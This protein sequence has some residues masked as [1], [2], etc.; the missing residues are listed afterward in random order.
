MAGFEQEAF[1]NLRDLL[2]DTAKEAVPAAEDAAAQVFLQAIRS[3]A[4]S[5]TGQLR[6]SIKIIESKDKSALSVE[7]GG[8]ARRRLFVGPEKKTGYYGYFVERGHKTAGSKRISRTGRGASHSQKGVAA[9]GNVEAHPWFVDAVNAA[10]PRALAAA[11]A[12]FD[13]KLNEL[14]SRK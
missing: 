14:N 9:T 10:E 1:G 11:R 8:T 6:A 5:K 12:A 13:D 3:A 2:V 4:P 7:A